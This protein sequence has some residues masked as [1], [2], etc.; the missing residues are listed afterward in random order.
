MSD[1]SPLGLGKDGIQQFAGAEW[2][3]EMCVFS[4]D[5][6]PSVH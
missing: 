3:Q 2:E 6:L 1:R 4:L 5:T